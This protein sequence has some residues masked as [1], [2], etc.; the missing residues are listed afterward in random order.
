[1]DLVEWEGEQV[2]AVL[3]EEAAADAGP[4]GPAHRPSL[5]DLTMPRLC[6]LLHPMPL[7]LIQLKASFPRLPLFRGRFLIGTRFGR[8]SAPPRV[9]G[10]RGND[11]SRL[12][13]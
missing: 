12:C 7:P 8:R 9:P 13:E 11:V 3:D 2:E 1:M 10:P 5:V 4:R 6:L